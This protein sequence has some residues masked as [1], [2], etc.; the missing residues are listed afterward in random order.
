M[1]NY[2]E[3][4][5]QL[6]GHE[7]GE[8]QLNAGIYDQQR[9]IDSLQIAEHKS[10]I[11]SAI[12]ESTD[13]AI[14]S[15]DLN[16]VITSWN[17]SAERMFGYAAHEVIGKSILVL[18]P[19]DRQEEE[20]LIL[21]RL[22][23]GHRVDHFETRRLTKQGELIDVSL[24]I[25]PV[26]D[27]NGNIIGLSK[28]A[29]DITDKKLEEQRKNDFIAIVSHE[30]KTPLTSIRSYIQ[31]AL[32][33][34]RQRADTLTIDVLSR[35][36]LQTKKMTTMI[37]DF[38]NLSRL[39]EGKMT[40]NLAKFSLP[41]LMDELV[42][43]ARVLA[44]AYV[45]NY[46]RFPEVEVY[47]DRDKISQVMTNLLSNAIKY[48]SSGS[49]ISIGYKLG[50]NQINIFFTDQGIGI[51]QDDQKR[52]FERFYRVRNEEVRNISGFGIGLYLVA[53]IL[54]LHGSHIMVESEPGKGSTFSFSLLLTVD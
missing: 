31:L 25:S 37:H 29:R 6:N 47:A 3:L 39:E 10:A 46:V 22:R 4:N 36:E 26:K 41:A 18:I 2:E 9:L 7:T 53:E 38:L 45:I 16:G 49:E 20:P 21:G 35:A 43:E 17:A 5:D 48:S 24:T 19:P 44:P 30:L 15:K 28:I 52:L 40:L 8:G 12:I 1:N 32:V 42:C 50:E 23:S 11:L 13:D 14:I 27:G 51:R 33:K 34:A 54:R